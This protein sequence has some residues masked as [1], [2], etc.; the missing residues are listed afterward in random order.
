MRRKIEVIVFGSL[1]MRSVSVACDCCSC[2]VVGVD[3]EE[4]LV[5]EGDVPAAALNTRDAPPPA[6]PISLFCTKTASS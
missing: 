6:Q 3:V 1:A 5:L 2:D 4:D